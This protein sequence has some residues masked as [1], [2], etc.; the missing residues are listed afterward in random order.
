MVGLLITHDMYI[1]G[2]MLHISWLS[3]CKTKGRLSAF[4][5]VPTFLVMLISVKVCSAVSYVFP[6]YIVRFYCI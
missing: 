2:S 1:N 6:C 5:V 3:L 4:D